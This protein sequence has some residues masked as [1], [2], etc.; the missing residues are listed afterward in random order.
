MLNPKESKMAHEP[1]EGK[2]IFTPITNKKT[3]NSPDWKGQLMHKGEI[4][5]FAGWIKKSAY[6]EFLS[7]AV[8]NYVPPAPQEYPREVKSKSNDDEVPF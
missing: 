8:D 7:L 5:K 4:V 3:P 6:G 1:S 2:G